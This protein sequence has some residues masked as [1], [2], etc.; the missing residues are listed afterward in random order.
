MQITWLAQSSLS[1]NVNSLNFNVL[2]VFIFSLSD[3]H[4]FSFSVIS[5]M[6]GREAWSAA[7]HGAAKS[8]TQLRDWTELKWPQICMSEWMSEVT[9]NLYR[10]PHFYIEDF[11]RW[12][13]NLPANAGDIR[14]TGLTP[15]WG[16]SPGEGNGNLL[17][18]SCLEN[19]MDRGSWW[20]TVCRIA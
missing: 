15:G 20:G 6:M 13:V 7:V 12:L 18:Y 16:R 8:W 17:Q 5:P 19:L 3:N 10:L 2:S 4:V 14:D 9:P 11:S 1:I